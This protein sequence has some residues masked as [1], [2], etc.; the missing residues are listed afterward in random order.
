MTFSVLLIPRSATHFEN[1]NLSSIYAGV[2]GMTISGNK[3]SDL[4]IRHFEERETPFY[5]L[6]F[7]GPL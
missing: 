1:I 6:L 5:F 7:H 3:Y 4:E 2:L